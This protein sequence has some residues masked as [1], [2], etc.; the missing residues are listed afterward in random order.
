MI[1]LPAYTIQL[2]A[3]QL[4]EKHGQIAGAT[5]RIEKAAAILIAGDVSCDNGSFF[6]TSS[7]GDGT[8]YHVGAGCT[9]PDYANLSAQ[10]GGAPAIGGQKFC[11]HRLAVAMLRRYIMEQLRPRILEGVDDAPNRSKIKW[12]AGKGKTPICRLLRHGQD[13]DCLS[14]GVHFGIRI[15]WS[16][17]LEGWCPASDADHLAAA[18]WLEFVAQP[19][20]FNLRP[21]M[22][23]EDA[24]AVDATFLPF[25]DWRELYGHLYR[26]LRR[27]Q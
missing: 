16:A 13:G 22:T 15:F 20:P 25:K 27:P 18:H 19:I 2:Y 26:D 7:K 17:K 9:C 14:D 1:H 11:K 24:E 23:A 10:A 21:G 12:Q 5:A 4:T 6:V 3:H 8:G